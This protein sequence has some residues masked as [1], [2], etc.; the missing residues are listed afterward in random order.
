[1][2]QPA[3]PGSTIPE[4]KVPLAPSLPGTFQAP[5]PRASLPDELNLGS[6][7]RNSSDSTEHSLAAVAVAVPTKEL[8]IQGAGETGQQMALTQGEVGPPSKQE[9]S[10]SPGSSARR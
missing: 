6:E 3:V 5:G 8:G 10:P 4:G 7:I 1:M 2:G 9:L